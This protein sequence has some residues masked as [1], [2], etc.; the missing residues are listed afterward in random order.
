MAPPKLDIGAAL[1]SFL[2]LRDEERA[3]DIFLSS[4]QLKSYHFPDRLGDLA[5]LEDF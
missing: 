4:V 2:K 5:K 1:A 3:I